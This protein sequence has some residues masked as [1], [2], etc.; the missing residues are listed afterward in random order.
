MTL[1][2]IAI[3]EERSDDG[4]DGDMPSRPATR[5]DRI[6]WLAE[7]LA[8][9]EYQ[10]GDAD[11]L[12]E[13]WG[14]AVRTVEHD[15]AAASKALILA[16]DD[17]GQLRKVIGIRLANLASDP[18][19]EPRDQIRAMEV[20]ARVAGLLKGAVPQTPTPH[21]E[22][23][24]QIVESIRDPNDTMEGLLRDA[25]SNPSARLLALVNEYAHGA[26]GQ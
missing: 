22:L 20:H 23:Q 15:V 11:R 10:R 9:G 16:A 2:A 7:R 8:T 26:G 17:L 19:V 3:A 18:S 14:L 6:R 21:A 4:R 5:D 24:A 12:A 1:R 13:S 25:L